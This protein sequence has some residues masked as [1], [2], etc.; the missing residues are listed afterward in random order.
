MSA[1]PN[2]AAFELGVLAGVQMAETPQKAVGMV[3]DIVKKTGTET[4]S[5]SMGLRRA[6]VGIIGGE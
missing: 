3:K 2:A 5:Q 4:S 6:T 1:E